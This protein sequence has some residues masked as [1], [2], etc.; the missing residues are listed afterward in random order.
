MAHAGDGSFD[1]PTLSGTRS[2][3]GRGPDDDEELRLA[4]EM[5]QMLIAQKKQLQEELDAVAGER[6]RLSEE[7]REWT[8]LAGQAGERS[9]SGAMAKLR[10][11]EKRADDLQ[12][13]AAQRSQR[14]VQLE[15]RV[16]DL[17]SVNADLALEAKA[18]GRQALELKKAHERL[19]VMSDAG[20]LA[21]QLERELV[22]VRG[23]KQR[24]ADKMAILEA[25]CRQYQEELRN[26]Q[27]TL[28]QVRA[29]SRKLKH[30]SQCAD[31]QTNSALSSTPTDETSVQECA[32][33][34][35]MVEAMKLEMAAMRVSA[36]AG[37][38]NT[39]AKTAYEAK[40]EA[41]AAEIERLKAE[42]A[43]LLNLPQT[44]SAETEEA[45]QIR[46]ATPN[47]N[48]T[49]PFDTPSHQDE[50]ELAAAAQEMQQVKTELDA[51]KMALQ[52]ERCR[53]AEHVQE[54]RRQHAEQVQL[55]HEQM[56]PSHV[57]L[58]AVRAEG[59]P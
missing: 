30:S 51:T 34:L 43:S 8:S 28:E 9:A 23:E 2:E 26:S 49:N 58:P 36:Q 15:V 14:I 55:S 17:E 11:A 33:A 6:D 48:S 29:E 45:G 40:L 54:L 35:E 19:K 37:S 5:G 21:A 24:L 7:L 47:C 31:V 10:H 20:A 44:G 22:G 59:E 56:P 12:A 3:D 46:A 25:D 16:A 1:S 53:H 27:E 42:I 52:T 57:S 38:D 4:A 41:Q 50:D 39:A 18:G 13:E 32:E